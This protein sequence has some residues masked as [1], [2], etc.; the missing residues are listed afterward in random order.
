MKFKDLQLPIYLTFIFLLGVINS[1]SGQKGNHHFSIFGGFNNY[2]IDKPIG[3]SSIIF[4]QT[5]IGYG[6]GLGRHINVFVNAEL[7]Q[8]G[9]SK[10]VLFP[11]IGSLTSQIKSAS[12]GIEFRLFTVKKIS[13]KT[14]LGSTFQT[15]DNSCACVVGD[16]YRREYTGFMTVKLDYQISKKWALFI[17]TSGGKP[18][19]TTLNDPDYCMSNKQTDNSKDVFN[20]NVFGITFQIES[21][22]NK[23]SDQ[24]GVSDELDACPDTPKGEQVN[25]EGCSESQL[26]EDR[27]G[28][29]NINDK[30]PSTPRGE[31]VNAN[32]CSSSQL[33]D[34]LDGVFNKNDKCPNTPKG[35]I[36]NKDGCSE[37]Q[38]DEDKDGVSNIIDQCKGTLKG[39]LVNS[40]GCAL[41]Q[42]DTDSDGIFDDLDKCPEEKGEKLNYGCPIVS[43]KIEKQISEIANEVNFVSGKS[44]LLVSSM[45]KLNE[46]LVILFE[47]PELKIIISGHTDDVGNEE[48]NFVL[49]KKRADSVLNYLAGKGISKSRMKSFAFGEQ[50][51]KQNENSEDARSKNRR[52]EIKIINNIR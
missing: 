50:Q 43:K 9:N 25:E 32:G 40:S 20:K 8:L 38:I 6:Y 21:L 35:E 44:D 46:L 34:D 14:S 24:D 23:D 15:I 13:L 3:Q 19:S 17:S 2:S 11:S 51:L 27:D 29:T 22:R 52:V 16:R 47:N 10:I 31:K 37:S 41:N 5:G 45:T 33:D 18:Y 39:Q 12:L 30:C 28:V 36:V 49:S 4:N 26:D 42:L 48:S 1:L 7:G